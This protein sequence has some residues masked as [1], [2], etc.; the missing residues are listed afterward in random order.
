MTL[1]CSSHRFGKSFRTGVILGLVSGFQ[2]L[3]KEATE[4]PASSDL[5][6]RPERWLCSE[7][8]GSGT[9]FEN[10]S[11]RMVF[12]KESATDTNPYFSRQVRLVRG[13]YRLTVRYHTDGRI[14][15]T[16]LF[17]PLDTKGNPTG[18]TRIIRIP[19]NASSGR[20]ECEILTDSTELNS[21]LEL[22][23]YPGT[24]EGERMGVG[25]DSGFLPAG[26]HVGSAEFD[27]VELSL[28]EKRELREPVGSF[29][30]K[31]DE[32]VYK[33]TDGRELRVLVDLPVGVDLSGKPVFVWVHGG[34]WIRGRPEDIR[35]YSYYFATRGYPS[36]R[37]QY[38]LLGEGGDINAT[39]GDLQDALEWARRVTSHYGWGKSGFI[40]GGS[41]AG[42]HLAALVAQT[43]KDCLGPICFSGLYD[44]VH[45]G[46]GNFGRNGSFLRGVTVS[47]WE[48]GSPIYRLRRP[49]VPTLL[50]LGEQD[51]AIDRNQATAFAAAIQAIGGKSEV[52]ICPA[53]AH[54]ISLTPAVQTALDAY[55][56]RLALPGTDLERP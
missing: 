12:S 9:G 55:I 25:S 51:A 21:P 34:G 17:C 22:R 33:R 15:P 48:Q 26:Q 52:M 38:R 56:N 5:A 50:F 27:S 4:L 6:V 29:V 8:P 49:P 45:K 43:T 47:D 40:L 2:V 19:S 37:P 31:T 1:A 20:F 14:A 23:L 42:A 44:I 32:V 53:I 30:V 36:I 46:E 11:G 39:A 16:L 28:V 35:G 10:G 24:R 18:V 7:K 13:L 54:S 41:S 3:A